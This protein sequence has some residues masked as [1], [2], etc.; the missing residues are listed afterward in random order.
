MEEIGEFLGI[1][2]AENVTEQGILLKC[3]TKRP[4]KVNTIMQAED[5]SDEEVF[6]LTGKGS[7]HTTIEIECKVVSILIYSGSLINV[8]DKHTF[9]SLNS[10]QAVK[11]TTT[12]IYPYG[13]KTPFKLIGK[14]AL[15]A[16]VNDNLWKIEFYII[17]GTGKSINWQ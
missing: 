11:K 1:L 17:A 4:N 6:T 9:D 15:K 13:S 3:K 2:Y 14:S 12:T 8:I 16:R 10:S 5:N 7:S